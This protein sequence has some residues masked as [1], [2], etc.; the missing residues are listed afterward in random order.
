MFGS[1]IEN[2]NSSGSGLLIANNRDCG[3]I[4][5]NRHVVDPV[6]F[7]SA[8]NVI[9]ARYDVSLASEE[10]WH[11]AKVAA[12]HN[13]LDLAILVVKR[14]FGA[15][16]AVRVA[17]LHVIEQGDEV[18]ALGN[19]DGIDFVTT[20]GIVSKLSDDGLVTT[21][22]I[23]PG[24]SGGPLISRNKGTVVAFNTWTRVDLQNFNGAVLA[25]RVL[26][27]KTPPDDSRPKGHSIAK[28]FHAA[29]DTWL[30][31]PEDSSWEWY[32][33]QEQVAELLATIPIEKPN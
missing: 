31:D 27:R 15:K 8:K 30:S 3:V 4:V 32:A 26:R 16:G 20:E 1:T 9:A 7:G 13:D 5:T 14:R 28:M 19:P 11:E 17:S 29:K 18:V 12:I 23:N 6:Y 25:E 22:P 21:C 10:D 33:E 24:N 2:G